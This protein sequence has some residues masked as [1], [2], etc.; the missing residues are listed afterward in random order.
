MT[1]HINPAMLQEI[2]QANGVDP[3]FVERD[4]VL[5]EII[6]HLAQ[7]PGPDLVLK[8]GQ[9]LRHIYGSD[10]LSKDI[11]YVSSRRLD[12]DELRQQLTIRYPRLRLPAHAAGPTK[13]GLTIR[14]II[15][16]GPLNV[17][18]TVEVEVSYREDV[19]LIPT[20]QLFNNP[21]RDPFP[22]VVM[23]LH[24]MVAEK[25][26]ALYQRGNPRDLYD[27]WFIHALPNTAIDARTVAD[28]VPTKFRLV[29]G[30]WKRERL[31]ER[32]RAN[33]GDWNQALRLLVTSL[34]AFDDALSA[35]EAALRPVVHA[36]P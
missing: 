27:L 7:L 16:T 26:R 34:P 4:W 15:Y 14:P 28:L 10:R 8:G 11:D 5:T 2:A 19:V 21:F 32:I 20:P 9:A 6:F 18:G 31:Y 35:V 3:L 33:E 12:F 25:I 36:L 17:Q 23:N 30:G 13:Y 1:R 24:E 29:S 22:V